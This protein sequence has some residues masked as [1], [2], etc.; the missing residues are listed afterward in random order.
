M[1]TGEEILTTGIADALALGP[2]CNVDAVID[3]KSDVRASEETRREYRRQLATY[4]RLVRAATGL[5]VYVT[6]GVVE[7]V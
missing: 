1:I 6:P 5:V 7:V 2:D 4:K 3:W